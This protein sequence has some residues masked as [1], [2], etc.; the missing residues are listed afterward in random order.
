MFYGVFVKSYSL[1]FAADAHNAVQTT[2]LAL[3]MIKIRRRNGNLCT[4]NP[5]S[6]VVRI[7]DEVWQ[8]VQEQIVDQATLDAEKEELEPYVGGCSTC[9]P[10]PNRPT[11]YNLDVVGEFD[12]FR[13]AFAKGGGTQ[14]MLNR[15]S[16]VSSIFLS[17]YKG[18]MKAV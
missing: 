18:R 14:G 10:P 11:R 3:N 4:S 15:R 6:A 16:E 1:C 8:L 12:D 13:D 7:P 2:L 17:R 9:S 5:S